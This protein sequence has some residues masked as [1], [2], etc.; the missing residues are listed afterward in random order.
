MENFLV[1]VNEL[2]YPIAAALLGGFF[3]FLSLKYI[4]DGVIDDVTNIKNIT[5]S[6]D[7]RIKT[8]NHDMIRMDISMCVVLGIKPDHKRIARADGKSDVRRD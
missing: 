7:N 4:M 5:G 8:M 1:V 6:L 3:M 2:G